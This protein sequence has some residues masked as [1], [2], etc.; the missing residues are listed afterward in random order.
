MCVWCLHAG[1]DYSLCCHHI[2]SVTVHVLQILEHN[3]EAG[4][5]PLLESI[6]SL[7]LLLST[8][9]EEVKALSRDLTEEKAKCCRLRHALRHGSESQ[10]SHCWR[11][12]AA[13]CPA[14]YLALHGT[15]NCL[16][17][18]S[19]LDIHYGE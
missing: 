13:L 9:E 4:K 17:S 2:Q 3:A 5:Q 7:K 10:V 8:K 19:C 14:P 18:P 11:D 16:G 12:E 6:C 15:A 1:I